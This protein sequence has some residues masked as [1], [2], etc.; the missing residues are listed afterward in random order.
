MGGA[1]SPRCAAGSSPATAA[2]LPAAPAGR[3]F[4]AGWGVGG[5]D[6]VRDRVRVPVGDRLG[7]RGGRS[8][9]A[10]AQG[11]RVRDGCRSSLRRWRP[12]STAAPPRS[13]WPSPS[14]APS[15]GGRGRCPRGGPP[16]PPSRGKGRA[17]LR[18]RACGWGRGRASKRD[19]APGRRNS[20][21]PSLS[22]KVGRG[23]RRC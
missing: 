12:W 21:G 17:P 18:A 9:R 15:A 20:L 4:G 23:G 8:P 19:A 7:V 6:R 10:P 16:S 22:P 1:S 3:G 5:G 11:R 2:P 13:S 14:S